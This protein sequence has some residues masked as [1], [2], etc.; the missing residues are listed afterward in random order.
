M[1]LLWAK[2]SALP[3]LRCSQ[4]GGNGVTLLVGSSASNP[5]VCLSTSKEKPWGKQK[6]L[7]CPF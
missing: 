2:G 6:P 4:E 3:P 7:Q 1:P 5:S